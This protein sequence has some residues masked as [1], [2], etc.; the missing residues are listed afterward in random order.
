MTKKQLQAYADT[1]P[2]VLPKDEN[3]DMILPRIITRD[4]SY[5]LQTGR[6]APR[7]TWNPL[8]LSGKYKTYNI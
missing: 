2:K 7:D 6:D 1:N 4:Y 5:Q 8:K 3:G